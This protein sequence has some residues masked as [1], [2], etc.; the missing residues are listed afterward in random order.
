MQTTARTIDFVARYGGEEFVLVLPGTD[1]A[2][3]LIVAE[4]L[5]HAI[6]TMTGEP[7]VTASL[8]VAD[9]PQTALDAAGLVAAADEALYSAKQSGRNRVV[10]SDRAA[11]ASPAALQHAP[12]PQRSPAETATT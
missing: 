5:R 6:E 7:P 3:A 2:A 12:V 4:R 9:F 1:A 8:G 10:R 11:P